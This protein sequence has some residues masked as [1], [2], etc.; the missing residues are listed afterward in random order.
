MHAEQLEAEEAEATDELRKDT[1]PTMPNICLQVIQW[2]SWEEVIQKKFAFLRALEVRR[3]LPSLWHAAQGVCFALSKVAKALSP[4]IQSL[5]SWVYATADVMNVVAA[6]RL[7]FPA[8]KRFSCKCSQL[9]E[10][11]AHFAGCTKADI[12]PRSLGSLD[13]K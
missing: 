8:S 4:N 7:I 1:G 3:V 12:Y 6:A 10:A 11:L 9:P 13:R 5:T 2:N